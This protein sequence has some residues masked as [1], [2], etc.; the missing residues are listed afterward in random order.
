MQVW[1]NSI[2]WFRRYS[3]YK[4]LSSK[5]SS[6]LE[7]EVKVTKIFSALKLVPMMYPCKFGEIPS[8]GSRD[9][10]GTRNCHLSPAVTLKMRS[11]SPKSNQL[12]NLSQWYIHA[13]LV[14]FHPLVQEI[15]CIQEIFTPFNP[16]VTLKM[17]SRSPKSNQLLNLS[18]WYIHASLVKFH[19]LV[20]E[21]LCIQEIF[22]PFKSSCD[23]ENEVKVTKI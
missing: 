8:I 3:G 1:W 20:Q 7:N 23:L 11:R 14:K 10:V 9:I 17:R 18:Q 6:D 13:S 19:P 12:L 2:H 4:K 22:T 21:I 16:P 5:S 15:L